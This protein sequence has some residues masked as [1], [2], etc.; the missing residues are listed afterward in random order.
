MTME[1]EILLTDEFVEFSQ[2]ITKIHI[3]KKTR[4]AEFKKLYDAF[5]LEMHGFDEQ[6]SNLKSE[7][8]NFARNGKKI[9]TK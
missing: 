7:W 1:T 5:M 2:K 3:A 8:E 6:V 4:Q 9:E